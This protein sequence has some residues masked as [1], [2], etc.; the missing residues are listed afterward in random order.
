MAKI[1]LYMVLNHMVIH[2]IVPLVKMSGLLG[3]RD[4]GAL[5]SCGLFDQQR[6]VTLNH[7]RGRANPTQMRMGSMSPAA[8]RTMMIL[9]MIPRSL[10]LW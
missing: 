5:R 2:Y 1:W 7:S 4:F 10:A 6:Q 9:P 3:A 8:D